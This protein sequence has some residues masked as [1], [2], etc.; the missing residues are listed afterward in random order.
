MKEFVIK[1]VDGDTISGSFYEA[2][3]KEGRVNGN[4]VLVHFAFVTED[5]SEV[6]HHSGSLREGKLENLG[7]SLD[8]KFFAVWKASRSD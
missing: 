5:G 1:A 7:H 6:Y 3:L 8:R 4:R 2:D